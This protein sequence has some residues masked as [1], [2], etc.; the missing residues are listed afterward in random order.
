VPEQVV[1]G[2]MK[3]QNV[4]LTRNWDIAKIADVGVARFAKGVDV[5]GNDDLA[6]ASGPCRVGWTSLSPVPCSC[7]FD[8]FGPARNGNG[9]KSS[10]S[11]SHTHGP[12]EL[13]PETY[14]AHSAAAWLSICV[15][16]RFQER[17]WCLLRPAI[18][19]QWAPSHMLRRK[20]CSAWTRG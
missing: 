12:A 8:A 18:L 5:A 15:L 19:L 9:P 16:R 6:S 14:S 17:S 1:H 7:D 20:C 4:L 11:T 2:D 3:S 10:V 13:A